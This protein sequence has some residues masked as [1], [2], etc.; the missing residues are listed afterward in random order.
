MESFDRLRPESRIWIFQSRTT[1]TS[2]ILAGIAERARAFIAQWK[3]HGAD[4]AAGFTL[5]YN[6]FLIVALDEAVTSAGGCSIDTL[7]KFV[8]GLEKE[9]GLS[10]LDRMNIAWEQDG[11]VHT[12]GMGAFEELLDTGKLSGQTLVFNNLVKTKADL[13]GNWKIPLLKSWHS[14]LMKVK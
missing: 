7:L 14:R 13:I 3:S 12:A 11:Q 10:L 8:Q 4:V 2:E 5:A 1:L 9:F 6:H